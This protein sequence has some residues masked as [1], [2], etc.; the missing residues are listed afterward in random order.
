MNRM[1]SSRLGAVPAEAWKQDPPASHLRDA[2]AAG[3]ACFVIALS[4]PAATQPV[5]NLLT[6]LNLS[7]YTAGERPPPFSGR[8]HLGREVSLAG[9][10]GKVVLLNF[11]ATWCYECRS[12]M[13]AFERLHQKFAPRGLTVIGVNVREGQVA[14]RKYTDELGLTFPLLTDSGGKITESYGV[15]GLPSTFL[16]G[17]DGRAVALAVGP[18]NWD[19]IDAH[20]L[21]EALL[22]E[23]VAKRETP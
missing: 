13:P 6:K 17:R 7:S 2:L 11:W 21:I 9:L 22:A 1:T 8:T 19:R 18:R 23:P 20:N 16:I 12:E 15:I 10:K 3:L 14:I 5:Q 4:S